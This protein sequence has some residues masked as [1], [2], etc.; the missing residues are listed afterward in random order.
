MPINRLPSGVVQERP[1]LQL[2]VGNVRQPELETP[3]IARRVAGGLEREDTGVRSDPNRPG[4]VFVD[5]VDAVGGD[6]IA[7]RNRR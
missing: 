7:H 2:T 6:R 1:D 5:H 4:A 3:R